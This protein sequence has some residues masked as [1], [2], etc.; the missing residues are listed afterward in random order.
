MK[1]RNI[2]TI[3]V[4]VMLIIIE[5]NFW[6]F[7][8]YWGKKHEKS[9]LLGTS[10]FFLIAT[11]SYNIILLNNR[12]K[13]YPHNHHLFIEKIKFISDNLML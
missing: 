11:S 3:S 9:Q 4:Y 8:I 13:N 6:L 1:N 2:D 5:I 10:L 7:N 12:Q